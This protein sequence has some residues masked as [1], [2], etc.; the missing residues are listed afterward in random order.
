MYT[1]ENETEVNY[2]TVTDNKIT[3]YSSRMFC[4]THNNVR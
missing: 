2:T 3:N 1:R 4:D